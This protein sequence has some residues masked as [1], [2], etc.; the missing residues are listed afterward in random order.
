MNKNKKIIVFLL[1]FS[2][3]LSFSGCFK[4]TDLDKICKN[5][6]Q[7]NM[8]LTYNDVEHTLSA[9]QVIRYVN[10]TGSVLTNACFHLYANNFSDGAINKPVSASNVTKAYPNGFSEGHIEI[11]KVLVNNKNANFELVGDDENIL[12]VKFNVALQ[13]TALHEIYIKYVVKIPNILHRFGYTDKSV[14]LANFYPVACVFENGK[15]VTDPYNSNGD[16]FYSDISSYSVTLNY[17]FGYEVAS[18]GTKKVS[19][20]NNN[21]ICKISAKAVRDF[22]IVMSKQFKVL[23]QE[24]EG[25][26]VNYFYYGD[27]KP[28]E[29]LK[30][31]VNSVK[32][33][34]NLFGK[35]PYSTLDVVE[36]GFLHGGMEFPNLVMISDNLETYED[37]TYVIVHEIAHQWW[38]GLVGNNQFSYGWLD[39]GLAEYACMLFY[40]QNEEYGIDYQVLMQNALNNYKLF[41]DVYRQVYEK[42]ETTLNRDLC[43][44]ATEP[45]YSFTAY[46]KAM[47]MHD[48]LRN[49][50]GT[51]TY[52]KCLKNYFES[53]K[54]EIAT[55]EDMILC[56][57]NSSGK[58]LESFFNAWINGEVVFSA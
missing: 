31:S 56:F 12:D 22:A 40:E 53:Y 1:I 23:S 3:F 15:F 20:D 14:N 24:V 55:P 42:V 47:L 57:S 43:D 19:K 52:L 58:D 18:T 30:T 49:V 16:P 50:L 9:E 2:V 36:T 54:F 38:Y 21:N 37:Y 33:F 39:E 34:N 45:E 27:K 46:T 4:T 32:T 44:F 35:Y 29:S 8:V 13:P 25:V 7:Y 26:V 41:L 51:K 11:K 17:P 6:N 48:A 5:K 28:E 10:N